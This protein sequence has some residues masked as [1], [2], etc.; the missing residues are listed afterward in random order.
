MVTGSGYKKNLT[1]IDN[2][3]NAKTLT[4]KTS[5][6]WIDASV[7]LPSSGDSYN[8][9][10]GDIN[11]DGYLDLI[12]TTGQNTNTGLCAMIGNGGT[13][14][15]NNSTGLPMEDWYTDMAIGD[16]NNDGNLDF[17]AGN[18]TGSGVYLGNGGAG[19]SM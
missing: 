18:Y 5:S 10:L 9:I 13:S 7:G 17:V 12:Y 16:L 11:K 8:V 14:W 2:S 19:G 3:T 15:V 1:L 4:P 6:D